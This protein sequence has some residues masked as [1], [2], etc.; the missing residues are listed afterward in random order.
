MDITKNL[1]KNIVNRPQEKIKKEKELLLKLTAIF[2]RG[3]KKSAANRNLTAENAAFVIT[4][5]TK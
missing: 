2:A 1:L 5:W 4:R 3:S